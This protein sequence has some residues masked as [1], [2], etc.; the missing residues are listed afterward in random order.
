MLLPVIIPIMILNSSILYFN[1]NNNVLLVIITILAS[2]VNLGIFNW[3]GIK[4]LLD[5]KL[6]T[7]EKIINNPIPLV[8]LLTYCIFIIHFIRSFITRDKKIISYTMAYV[9]LGYIIYAMIPG[10]ASPVNIPNFFIT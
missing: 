2:I 10:L 9:I 3:F 6:Y 1:H 5:T 4:D 7:K 8:S